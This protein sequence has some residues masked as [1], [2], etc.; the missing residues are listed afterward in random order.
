MPV[1]RT[2][3]AG[4]AGPGDGA[5]GD[6]NL[7]ETLRGSRALEYRTPKATENIDRVLLELCLMEL[8]PSQ[9]EAKLT[10]REAAALL[11]PL[12]QP[13]SRRGGRAFSGARP[14]RPVLL[15]GLEKLEYRG[16]DSAGISVLEGDDVASVR[17]V[18]NPRRDRARVDQLAHLAGPIAD[19]SGAGR[20][21]PRGRR[22]SAPRRRGRSSA[23]GFEVSTQP[24]H[25]LLWRRE[26]FALYLGATETRRRRRWRRQCVVAR[27]VLSWLRRVS[28][29]SKQTTTQ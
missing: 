23:L 7:A 26:D 28:H 22:R 9:N 16:Y 11:I 15:A 4:A 3:R 6:V 1:I 13:P 19:R 17:A 25:S 27:S 10:A 21:A 18:G 12:G 8:G 20:R 2:P 14:C 24:R 29:G 5:L